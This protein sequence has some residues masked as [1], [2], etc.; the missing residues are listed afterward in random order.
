MKPAGEGEDFTSPD[1]LEVDIKILT[2]SRCIKAMFADLN[3]TPDQEPKGLT[4]EMICAGR[5]IHGV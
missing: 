5:G 2:D 1:L 3:L 4:P